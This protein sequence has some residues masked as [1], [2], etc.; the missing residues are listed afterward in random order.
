MN[1]LHLL[2]SLAGMTMPVLARSPVAQPLLRTSTS[3]DLVVHAPYAKAAP[4]EGE[5]LWAGKHW[6]P[7][8]LYPQ[9]AADEEGMVFTIQHGPVKAVWVNT[10]FDVDARHF[11]YVYVI[12]EIMVTVIDVRFKIISAEQT[13]VRVVYT[14]TALTPEGNEHVNTMTEGDKTAGQEWEEALAQYLSHEKAAAHS[15]Q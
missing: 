12:P 15:G 5:R 9:P 3:F 7:E 6:N 2:V 13:G 14:R 8:V 1:T 10:M 4:P 11:Q